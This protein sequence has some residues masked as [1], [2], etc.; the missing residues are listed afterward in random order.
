[1]QTKAE[2]TVLHGSG[3][4]IIMKG[5]W[6]ACAE[7][8]HACPCRSRLEKDWRFVLLHFQIIFWQPVIVWIFRPH[9]LN[10]R[11]WH[12]TNR[13]AAACSRSIP[14]SLH[15]STRLRM[16]WGRAPTISPNHN[17]SPNLEILDKLIFQTTSSLNQVMFCGPIK[18]KC[19]RCCFVCLWDFWH[20]DSAT[21]VC[22][23]NR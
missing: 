4:A 10:T 16:S 20:R 21:S 13:S 15:H 14:H 6:R 3:V 19:S 5:V 23:G 18:E 2:I 9:V 7:S 11:I 8:F 12:S 1:M 17:E 22:Y